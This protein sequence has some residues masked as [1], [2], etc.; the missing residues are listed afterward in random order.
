MVTQY[1]HKINKLEAI[2]SNG[3]KTEHFYHIEIEISNEMN[4]NKTSQSER[5]AN[6][7]LCF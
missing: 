4:K 6:S 1:A 7:F 2:Q 5:E 3:F